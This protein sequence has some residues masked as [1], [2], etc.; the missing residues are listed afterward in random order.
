[1]FIHG[2]G[3]SGRIWREHMT[4]LSGFHCLA[5][6]LPG[7]GRSNHL[8]LPS[9]ERITDLIAE[10]IETRVPAGRAS[11]VGISWG[12]VIIHALLDRHPDRVDRAVIDGAPLFW[13]RGAGPLGLLIIAAVSPFLHTRPVMALFG[14]LMDAEDLRRASRRA[15]LRVFSESRHPSA[16]IGASCP[17]L[18][19]AGEKE[20]TVRPADAALASLMPH[21]KARFAPGLGH[22][23]QRKAPDLHIRTVEAWLTG[24]ELPSEL[25]P[26]PA[27]SPA[28]VERLRRMA[29]AMT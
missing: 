12:G 3:Q 1:V 23:W 28:T 29:P 24:Q 22:C 19:V 11:V 26:E 9:N 15:F 21:A 4:R 10:L 5:P 25:P 14:D 13:P 2:M 17:T 27:P 18:L 8:P 20:S 16:T 7:F 6:D